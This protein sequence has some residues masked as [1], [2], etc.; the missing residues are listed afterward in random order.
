[1]TL[2][3]EWTA[4]SPEEAIEE[5]IFYIN[6]LELDQGI[7]NSLIKKLEV[8]IKS[9]EKGNI[10]TAANQLEAFINE[11]KAQYD[12]KIPEEIINQLLRKAREII[13]ELNNN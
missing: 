11:L 8:A 12:K 9:I 7:S 13:N 2:Y 4:I 10:H 6:T 5:L 1:M 3:A